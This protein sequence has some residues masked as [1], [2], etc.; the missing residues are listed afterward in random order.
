MPFSFWETQKNNFKYHNK[1]EFVSDSLL[2]SDFKANTFQQ[3]S[4]PLFN[5]I[6]GDPVYLYSWQSRDTTKNEFTVIKHDGE[7]GLKMFYFILDKKDSLI[8]WTQIGG[9]G[10]EG[11][12]WFETRSKFISKDTILKVGAITQ[13]WDFEKEKNMEKTKGDSTFSHMIIDNNGRMTK[14]VFKEVKDIHFATE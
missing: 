6:I 7:L 14:K 11:G 2:W 8:S 3:I 13:W 10:N 1:I 9:K 4:H 5:S 12:Y